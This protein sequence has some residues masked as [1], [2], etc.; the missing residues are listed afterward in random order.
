MSLAKHLLLVLQ[1]HEFTVNQSSGFFQQLFLRMQKTYWLLSYVIA[2]ILHMRY[3]EMF[4]EKKCVFDI[5]KVKNK[6]TVSHFGLFA[7]L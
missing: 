1:T 7:S 5:F 4:N 3:H 6:F 2:F